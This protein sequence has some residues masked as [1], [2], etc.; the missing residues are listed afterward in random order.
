MKKPYN[1]QLQNEVN[2]EGQEGEK[3]KQLMFSDFNSP[4]PNTTF[5]VKEKKM[6]TNVG[7]VSAT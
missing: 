2:I 7:W 6:C 1:P 5:G 3:R 4:C